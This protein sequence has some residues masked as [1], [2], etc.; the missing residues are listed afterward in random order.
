[1]RVFKKPRA[2]PEHNDQVAFFRW[3]AWNLKAYPELAVMYAIAN[4]G[5][6]HIRVAM[7]L[8]AEG[9]KAGVPDIALPVPRGKYAA[10]YIEMKAGK[11][12][13]TPEQDEW[14]AR[15]NAL[16]NLAIV[17]HGWTEAAEAVKNY[18]EL[19]SNEKEK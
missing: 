2:T 8:K 15:L 14:L 6:R 16:G 12:T 7:N 3:A 13:T 11:N 4:G 19:G 10:L 5:H 1:M 9:V 17:C 18:L